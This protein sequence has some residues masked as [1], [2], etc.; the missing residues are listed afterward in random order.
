[1]NRAF[2]LDLSG[3][4]IVSQTLLPLARALALNSARSSRLQVSKELAFETLRR[5]PFEVYFFR[6]TFLPKL[7]SFSLKTNIQRRGKRP[8]LLISRI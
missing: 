7:N 2:V 4:G 1:M 8:L 5:S 3:L 6:F